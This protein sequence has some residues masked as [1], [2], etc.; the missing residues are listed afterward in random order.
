MG[1]RDASG[2]TGIEAATSN[3]MWRLYAEYGRANALRGAVGVVGT[4]AARLFGLVPAFVVGLTID[5][6]FLDQRAYALPAV[7]A[8]WLPT[9]PTGQL[10]ASIA[11][12][13]AATILGAAATW[14]QN[15]G[16]NSFA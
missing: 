8:G 6:V 7:P 12:L 13:L 11:V 4:V 16:W 15:W 5:A 14:T 2:T 9:D 3:P 10:W 1:A